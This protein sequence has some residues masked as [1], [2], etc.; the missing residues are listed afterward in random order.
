MF[1][2][3]L[4]AVDLGP[5]S[6]LLIQTALH[7]PGVSTVHLFH[8]HEIHYIDTMQPEFETSARPKL[9]SLRHSLEQAGKQVF[10]H[11]APGPA[12][13]EIADHLRTNSYDLLLLGNRGHRL[14]TELLLGS[15]ATEILHAVKTPIWLH[16]IIAGTDH[17]DHAIPPLTLTE[18][19]LCASDG[20]GSKSLDEI[21]RALQ[22]QQLDLFHSIVEEEARLEWLNDWMD[23]LKI[24]DS[25]IT[26]VIRKGHPYPNL[27]DALQ[28]RETT[29]LV[30]KI[31]GK[32][33]LTGLVL[34][35]L[36]YRMARHAK[37]DLLLVPESA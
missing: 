26:P 18:R 33:F 1:R 19:V 11:T 13:L 36:S 34:G 8:A 16:R 35:S 22:P 7:I 6:D 29:L 15:T 24:A 5:T 25:S 2:N 12:R 3:I 14:P 31:T 32:A 4:I 17:F 9:E 28:E 21:L 37:T 23:R 10:L 27:L 30:M 20:K